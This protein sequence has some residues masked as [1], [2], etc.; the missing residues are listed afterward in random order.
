MNVS[1]VSVDSLVEVR[2]DSLKPGDEFILDS[3]V[4]VYEV[5]E[6]VYHP[7][8]GM[9]SFVAHCPFNK[10]NMTMTF[11]RGHIVHKVVS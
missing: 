2:V 1:G 8:T 3:E 4:P 6:E 7:A 11:Y 9:F 10:R 5:V